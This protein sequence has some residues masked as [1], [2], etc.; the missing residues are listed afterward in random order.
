MGKKAVTGIAT[1]MRDMI[2][3]KMYIQLDVHITSS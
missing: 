1:D 2:P 3:E